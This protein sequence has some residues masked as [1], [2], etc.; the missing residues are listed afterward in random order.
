MASSCQHQLPPEPRP[1]RRR[2]GK[3]KIAA[4]RVVLERLNSLQRLFE[5]RQINDFWT[6]SRRDLVAT[7]PTAQAGLCITLL[8]S[9]VPLFYSVT[10]VSGGS[11][12][13]AFQHA[14]DY[15]EDLIRDSWENVA[16]K[17]CDCL[18]VLV[19]R[20][21]HETKRYSHHYKT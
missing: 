4:H 8:E 2:D 6:P 3:A 9:M 5:E 13:T 12:S 19:T 20:Q 15:F 18:S 7:L 21:E 10:T 17:L 1:L 11:G 14:S 16:Y